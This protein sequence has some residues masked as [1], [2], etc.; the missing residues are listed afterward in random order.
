MKFDANGQNTLTGAIFV[1]TLEGA[2]KLVW[3]ADQAA[4]ALV[5][6]RPAWR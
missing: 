4:A 3:P 2:P 1:Q 5:W 6:P